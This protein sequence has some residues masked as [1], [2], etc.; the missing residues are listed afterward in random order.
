MLTE[1]LRNAQPEF[2]RMDFEVLRR[3]VYR[4]LDALIGNG[5]ANQLSEDDQR[6][7]EYAFGIETVPLLNGHGLLTENGYGATAPENFTP[8]VSVYASDWQTHDTQQGMVILLKG[9]RR[10]VYLRVN[11]N[12]LPLSL[13]VK[14]GKERKLKWESETE[15]LSRRSLALFVDAAEI[16]GGENDDPSDY[17]LMVTIDDNQKITAIDGGT[18]VRSKYGTPVM[19][20]FSERI[21]ALCISAKVPSELRNIW[22]SKLAQHRNLKSITQKQPGSGSTPAILTLAKNM[23][24]VVCKLSEPPSRIV[25]DLIDQAAQKELNYWSPETEDISFPEP[26]ADRLPKEDEDPVMRELRLI[27]RRRQYRDQKLARSNL[28]RPP[29][30]AKKRK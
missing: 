4:D 15:K 30:R 26:A 11:V 28:W 12:D 1:E 21:Y 7:R 20:D 14:G 2:G 9:T 17:H 13:I 27:E 10:W 25:R 22:W 5:F 24:F 8:L 3:N 18:F 16:K 29:K 23:V 19:T 6:Y